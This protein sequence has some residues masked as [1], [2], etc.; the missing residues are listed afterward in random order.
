MEDTKYVAAD[1]LLLLLLVLLLLLL[2]LLSSV[3]VMAVRTVLLCILD[4]QEK[5]KIAPNVL[6]P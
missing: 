3:V 5:F 1:L 6:Y 4:T 2:L